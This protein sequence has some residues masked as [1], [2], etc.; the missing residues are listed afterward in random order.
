MPHLLAIDLGHKSGLAVYGDDGR[1]VRYRSTNFGSRSR[2]KRAVWGVLREVEELAWVVVEGDRDLGQV[3]RKAAV[4]QGARFHNVPP[5]TWRA[6]LLHARQRRTGAVAKESADTLA[7]EVIAWSGA[8]RPT[9]LTD[10][11]AEAILIGLWGAL[12]VGWLA[13]NPLA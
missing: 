5:E 11:V 8:E 13:E 1:L 7:R 9:S 6:E 10:D 2:L 12:E 4:K 3:W